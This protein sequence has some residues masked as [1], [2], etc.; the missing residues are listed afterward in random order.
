MYKSKMLA[1]ACCGALL[2][3]CGTITRG[4]NDTWVVETTP[5][6]ASVSTSN[7]YQC[8]ST[9]CAIKM[10]RR[11]EF[12]AT[13]TLDGYQTHRVN[14]TYQASTAGGTAMAGNV[15]VGGLIGAGVDAYSGSMNDL[16]PNPVHVALVPVSA[17]TAA[18][19]APAETEVL[20]D[21]ATDDGGMA[22]SDL[23]G[24]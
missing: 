4:S 10:P 7:G 20:D 21:A 3:G 12:V 5:A 24:E 23:T 1:M 19:P 6:G 17:T 14:V 18:A 16:V 15:L 22:E 2:A 13:I 9:P 8:E 11:S